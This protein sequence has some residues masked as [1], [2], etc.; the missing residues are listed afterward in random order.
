MIS[1][2]FHAGVTVGDMDRS[3]EFYRDGLGLEVVNDVVLDEE[4]HRELLA[5]TFDAMRIVF[6]AIPGGGSIELIEYIGARSG[7][8]SGTPS[9]IG[10]GHMCLTATDI[11]SMAD[12]LHE[13]GF[14]SRSEK[15]V[16]VAAGPRRGARAIYLQDPDGFPVELFQAPDAA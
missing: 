16:T 6:L 5:M 3:L 7:R 15:P 11:E 1:S 8:F 14:T 4:Y 10:S 13:L 12:R 9:D 2:F